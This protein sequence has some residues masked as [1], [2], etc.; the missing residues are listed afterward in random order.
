VFSTS[1][2]VSPF[3]VSSAW[4]MAVAMRSA[5]A[6]RSPSV[7]APGWKQTAPT[8]SAVERSSSLARP[9]RARSHFASSGVAVLSTYAACTTI[10]SGAILVAAMVSRNRSARSGRTLT[11][12]L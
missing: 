3:T 8:P 4:M 6:S 10:R 1:T 2:R 12:S 5:A 7:A 11:L 9:S